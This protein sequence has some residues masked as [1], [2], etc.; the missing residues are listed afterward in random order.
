ASSLADELTD[1]DAEAWL[2]QALA[3]FGGDAPAQQMATVFRVP[4]AALREMWHT[5]RGREMARQIVFRTRSYPEVRRGPLRLVGWEFSRREA[6]GGK[7]TPE[8]DAVVWEAWQGVAE[9]YAGGKL[10]KTQGVQLGLAWQGTTG[11]LGWGA[12]APKLPPADRARLAY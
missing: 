10:G 9:L 1:D 2:R 8:Q 3:L 6:F 7:F 12:V 5:E 11:F 4:P